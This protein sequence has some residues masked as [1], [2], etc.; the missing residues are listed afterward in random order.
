MFKN[1]FS[2]S[3]RIRR[4]EYWLTA[5]LIEFILIP[6]VFIIGIGTLVG[7]ILI[8]IPLWISLAANVKRS[9]DMGN[10]GWMT[11]LPFY[12]PFFLAFGGS[13]QFTNEYGDSPKDTIYTTNNP[14]IIVNNY[15]SERI[16]ANV[17]TS[18]TDDS[19]KIS[20]PNE[21]KHLSISSDKSKI[22][23]INQNLLNNQRILV[24]DEEHI[25][26]IELLKQLKQLVDDEILTQEEFEQQKSNI[27]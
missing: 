22:Q 11:L 19:T 6:L 21:T 24:T 12:N 8:I 15:S 20:L 23:A 1:I 10:S 2:F 18:D 13:Q 27:L 3:G 4:T 26:K 14:Q 17:E 25:K 9:H 7:F 5:I 16:V